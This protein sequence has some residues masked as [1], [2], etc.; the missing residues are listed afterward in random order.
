MPRS[1]AQ[2]LSLF[3]LFAAGLLAPT[4]ALAWVSARIT[5][6]AGSFT[7]TLSTV[8]TLC[9]D[10]IDNDGDGFADRLDSDCSSGGSAGS[11]AGTIEGL[12]GSSDPGGD[13]IM[14]VPFWLVTLS[15]GQR[16][17]YVFDSL[18]ARGDAIYLPFMSGVERV[19]RG[20]LIADWIDANADGKPD[21]VLGDAAVGKY[22]ALLVYLYGASTYDARRYDARF[23]GDADRANI[24]AGLARDGDTLLVDL[25]HLGD[26]GPGYLVYNYLGVDALRWGT[27]SKSWAVVN[28]ATGVVTYR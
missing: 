20:A 5:I 21:V 7:G 3:T 8:E 6:P 1:S 25:G 15:T 22:G 10:G 4:A 12:G 18:D 23:T 9:K 17:L 27:L 28:E 16:E 11:G 19:S 24:A 14:P 2:L 26:A 13:E